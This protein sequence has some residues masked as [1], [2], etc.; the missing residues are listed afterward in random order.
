MKVGDRVR[1][2]YTGETG[3]ILR[4]GNW[5][6]DFNPYKVL[7]TLDGRKPLNNWGNF[8]ESDLEVCRPHPKPRKIETE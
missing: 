8:K 7:V 4:I 2:K 3:T 5:E 6:D 1:N